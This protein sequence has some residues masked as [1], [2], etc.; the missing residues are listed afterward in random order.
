MR[1]L[2][3]ITNTRGAHA[4]LPLYG[5][6]HGTQISQC[7]KVCVLRIAAQ[8]SIPDRATHERELMSGR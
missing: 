5:I 7:N 4:A 1:V 6:D 8:E 3:V 2:E